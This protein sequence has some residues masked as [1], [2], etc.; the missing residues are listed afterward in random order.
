MYTV[1]DDEWNILSAEDAAKHLGLE[2]PAEW[3]WAFTDLGVPILVRG[4]LDGE[5]VTFFSGDRATRAVDLGGL[6]WRLDII[7]A[8]YP[9]KWLYVADK[10]EEAQRWFSNAIEAAQSHEAK[11]VVEHTAKAVVALLAAT[12]P[13]YSGK[14]S[15]WTT[16]FHNGLLYR[17]MWQVQ[18]E[19]IT[20]IK[21]LREGSYDL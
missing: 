12:V 4:D 11:H 14:P 19:F 10:F 1:L 21:E 3:D 15:W 7:K 18:Q 5:F 2:N 8:K 16:D 20:V 9:N 17:A 6:A 13:L